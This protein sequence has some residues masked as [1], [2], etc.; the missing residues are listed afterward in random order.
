MSCALYENVRWRGESSGTAEDLPD[1]SFA[2]ATTAF[3]NAKAILRFGGGGLFRSGLTD[4]AIFPLSFARQRIRHHKVAFHRGSKR[5]A[6]DLGDSGVV[7]DRH[8]WVSRS[9]PDEPLR[10]GERRPMIS[11]PEEYYIQIDLKTGFRPIYRDDGEERIQ[12][13]TN[14]RQDVKNVPAIRRPQRFCHVKR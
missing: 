11:E 3:I 14:G 13:V 12:N 2:G 4:R 1:A 5:G 8:R 6:A 7:Y 9:G 10:L